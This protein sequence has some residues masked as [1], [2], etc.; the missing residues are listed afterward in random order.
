LQLLAKGQDILRQA[1]PSD[2]FHNATAIL[3][4]TDNPPTDVNV[5]QQA[6]TALQKANQSK[7]FGVCNSCRNFSEKQGE[8]FC[9]LTQEKLSLSD[10]EKICQEHVP[11]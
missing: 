5:F 6:L 7:S 2:L 11:L 9:E 3:Q 8:Y 10:T 4:T 1:R